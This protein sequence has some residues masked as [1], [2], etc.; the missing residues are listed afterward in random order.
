MVEH[1]RICNYY[2]WVCLNI[3]LMIFQQLFEEKWSFPWF[4]QEN[5]QRMTISEEFCMGGIRIRPNSISPFVYFRKIIGSSHI[6]DPDQTNSLAGIGPWTCVFF[7]FFASS[8]VERNHPS[9]KFSPKSKKIILS[10]QNSWLLHPNQSI[11]CPG[12]NISEWF[13]CNSWMFFEVDPSSSN[14]MGSKD[15][16]NF[17]QLDYPNKQRNIERLRE[18]TEYRPSTLQHLLCSINDRGWLERQGQMKDLVSLPGLQE[19]RR[20]V[21]WIFTL[22]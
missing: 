22:S 13:S 3:D 10:S 5:H 21:G 12:N 6:Y 4:Y 17:C 19:R 15:P 1:V 18:K 20:E 16:N 14:Q 8:F 11:S 2:N 7:A 9:I